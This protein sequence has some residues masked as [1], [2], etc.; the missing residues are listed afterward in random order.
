MRI[1]CCLNSDATEWRDALRAALPGASVETWARDAS[2]SEYAIVWRPPQEFFDTQPRLKAIFNAGAGVDALLNLRL[3]DGV[4][5]VRLEDAGMAEQMAD[6][7]VHAVLRHVR[8]FDVYESQARGGVWKPR[9]PRRKADFPIGVLGFGVLGE[10]VAR[11]LQTM[12]FPVH[13]WTR[14]PKDAIGLR[15]FTGDAG[16]EDFLAATRV[17][18]CLLPLTGETRGI[19]NRRTLALLRPEAYIVNV[20]RGGHVV[21]SDLIEALKEGRLAGAALDV[22]EQEPLPSGHPLWDQP[23]IAVTPH[24]SAATLRE[25]SVEQ[26]ARKIL[27]MERGD[28]ISGVVDLRRG[29]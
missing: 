6:Y 16:L 29:Y 26:I 24:I 12:G 1:A 2:P 3:P 14:T 7:V 13:A 20:A 18:V 22:F 5:L 23:G 19:V 15:V 17:L 10:Y 27:A 8:E 28:P 21:E 25:E 11:S 9:A 4:P